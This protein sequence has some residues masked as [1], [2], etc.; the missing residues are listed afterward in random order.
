[1]ETENDIS[2]LRVDK[3]LWAFSH[4]GREIVRLPYSEARPYLIGQRPRTDLL[5]RYRPGAAGTNS[6]EKDIL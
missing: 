4:N 3:R 6:K 2:A 1:M 5:E